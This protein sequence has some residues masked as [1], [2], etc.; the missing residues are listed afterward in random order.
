MPRGSRRD[1]QAPLIHLTTI[2]NGLPN[3]SEAR[4]IFVTL[5]DSERGDFDHLDVLLAEASLQIGGKALPFDTRHTAFDI[6]HGYGNSVVTSVAWT[7]EDRGRYAHLSYAGKY[8]LYL[9]SH[10][11]RGATAYESYEHVV[12][13]R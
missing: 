8:S 9:W 7:R 1:S 13:G 2:K 3:F 4:N 6:D 10:F 11:R 12:D 5:P